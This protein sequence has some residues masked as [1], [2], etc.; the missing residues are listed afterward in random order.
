[1]PASI[2][3]Y[4]QRAG[5]APKVVAWE[6]DGW[7]RGANNF[8]Q[9]NEIRDDEFYMAQNAEI[10]GKNSVRLPRR[11]MR[12]LFDIGG[13]NF[14]GFGIYKDS[15]NDKNE[16]LFMVD[17]R[18]Y[19]YVA[20]GTPEEVDPTK[21]WDAS[22]KMRGVQVRN[23]F[24][25]ST[26]E[27][28]ISKYDGTNITRWTYVS[29]ITGLT[30]SLSGSGSEYTYQ[31]AVTAVTENGETAKVE[32]SVIYGPKELDSSNYITNTWDRKTESVV[33]GYNIWRSVNGGDM[34]LLTYIAQPP[35]GSTV[36]LDDDGSY[37]QSYIWEAPNY[38]TTGGVKGDIFAS[39]ADSIFVAGDP[40][41]PDTVYF[42]GTGIYYE[43]FSP[44]YNG[45]WVKVSRGDGEPVTA[46]IGLE[47]YLVI[48]KETSIWKFY[49]SSS[50]NPTIVS[51]IPQYGTRSP[52][53][54]RRMEND[55]VFVGHD[56]RVRVLGYEPNILNVIRTADIS[57]RIQNRLD[58]IDWSDP[59]SIFG[60][61]FDQKYIVCDG[62]N[63]YPYD[64]RY[65][66]F[67]DIWTNFGF[68]DFVVWDGYNG[69]DE[70]FGG[71]GEAVYRLLVN[72]TYDDDGEN[73]ESYLRPKRIDGKNEF[74]KKFFSFTRFKF[75]SPRGSVKITTYRDGA[76]QADE[77]SIYFGYSGGFGEW[78]FGE[79]MFGETGEIEVSDSIKIIEKELY[80]EAFS[81]YHQIFV[82]GN[83]YNHC[84]VQGMMGKLEFEDIDYSDD[85][86]KI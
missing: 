41:A 64:R 28:S 2:G 45:G 18:F 23:A 5:T 63:A 82:V 58:A 77:V 12:K 50:G 76:T 8:A 6:F 24:Y 16:L 43:S 27:D 26:K 1:M 80:F 69:R 25:F 37:T 79:G 85:I 19:R 67:L 55:I 21:T 39:Y 35:S 17:G 57:N 9:D 62:E 84:I 54:V 22:A 70:L 52:D 78:V 81:V 44:A 47:D 40:D 73:I 72:N 36:S 29:D 51:L 38:N 32:T 7:A 11:G 3:R 56:R 13:N 65:L 49:F 14:Q 20:G 60:I 4:A 46:I 33:K 75:L 71:K 68:S 66:G 10:V 34:T 86:T 74:I 61:Y 48:F 83:Q 30:A 42:S 53:S 15:V 31:Y 59:T